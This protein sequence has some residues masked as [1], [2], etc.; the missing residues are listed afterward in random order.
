MGSMSDLNGNRTRGVDGRAALWLTPAVLNQLQM[1]VSSVE[2]LCCMPLPAR[3]YH[4][5]TRLQRAID[6][7]LD[8]VTSPALEKRGKLAGPAVGNAQ[9]HA[10]GALEELPAG[11]ARVR[12]MSERWVA[13]GKLRRS[14]GSVAS[15]HPLIDHMVDV[16]GPSV[17]LG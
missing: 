2:L 10:E 11:R 4:C 15:I 1:C 12:N 13:W 7:V 3:V 6:G 16:A 17:V 8:A 14:D 5:V 9:R